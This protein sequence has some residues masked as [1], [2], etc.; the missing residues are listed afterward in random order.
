MVI[1]RTLSKA[2]GLAGMRFGYL[3]GHPETVEIISR[4]IMSWNIS[5]ISAFGAIAALQD[6]EGLRKKIRDTNEGRDYIESELSKIEGITVYHTHGNYI[7]LDAT[8]TGMKS[9]EIVNGVLERD[10]IIL[11]KVSPF[12]NKTG[13]FRITIGSKKENEH[14]VKAVKAFFSSWAKAA[15]RK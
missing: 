11:R 1:S 3:L 12:K 14:C 7:L 15:V 6:Q 2:Y 9:A 4:T 8:P 13:L 10:G 5:T